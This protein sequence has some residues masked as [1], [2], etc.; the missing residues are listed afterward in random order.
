[1]YKSL[2]KKALQ[3]LIGL[4]FWRDDIDNDEDMLSTEDV[5]NWI[6]RHSS[7]YDELPKHSIPHKRVIDDDYRWVFVGSDIGE[8]DMLGEDE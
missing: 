2:N 3:E 7:L 8:I 1:M 4:G 6:F 5:G